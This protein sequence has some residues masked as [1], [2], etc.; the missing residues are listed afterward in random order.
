MYTCVC[1]K[2]NLSIFSYEVGRRKASN[3]V[4]AERQKIAYKVKRE[5]KVFIHMN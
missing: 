4:I 1:V 2:L 3:K 5:T